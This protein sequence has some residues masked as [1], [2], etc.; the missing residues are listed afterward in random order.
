[1]FQP[2]SQTRTHSKNLITRSGVTALLALALS[3]MG[4][5]EVPET[6]QPST[7]GCSAD[8]ECSVGETCQAGACVAS[9]PTR[10]CMS[11]A[12]CASG[13]RCSDAGE[14]QGM[15]DVDPSVPADP[16][17]PTEKEEACVKGTLELT[18]QIPTVLLLI[19]Q[20]GSMYDDFDAGDRWNVLRDALT[21]PDNGVVKNLQDKVR[22]GVAL[23]SSHNGYGDQ[24]NQTC[25]MLQGLDS[26]PIK[27]D[28]YQPIRD[29]YMA[30]SPS[31]DT[32]TA[33]SVAAATDQLLA[34]QEEGPKAILL[35]TD[36]NP[37]TCSDPDA[38]DQASQ[39]FSVNTVKSSYAAGIS[40]YVLSVG[41]E[42][43]QDH[44]QNLAN[45]GVG[46]SDGAT[47]AYWK[48]TDQAALRSALENIINGVRSCT[49]SLEGEIDTALVTEGVV[50]LD[51]QELVY[52]V[53]W[54]LNGKNEVELVGSRCDQL[55]DGDHALA[56][57]FPCVKN[58]V[59]VAVR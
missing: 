19:D 58:G 46:A 33:E 12:D 17:T 36:G 22:F 15:L 51:G 39:D 18:S 45:A 43:A 27:L 50:K 20:S 13:Q 5:A 1:M 47:S 41:D 8:S 49:F 6:T 55:K 3:A 35:A 38:H 21:D 11:N 28:N 31:D 7:I 29:L 44:L 42:V 2:T 52:G 59:P 14:C 30:A 10:E 4:C 37:D 26:V 57:E 24:G 9:A 16:V 40:T 48:A 34:Y 54:K 56:A 25:P 32:P 53:D 23:Y